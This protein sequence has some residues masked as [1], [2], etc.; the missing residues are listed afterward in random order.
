MAKKIKI[1]DSLRADLN[2]AARGAVAG[3]SEDL[4]NGIVVAAHDGKIGF[5]LGVHRRGHELRLDVQHALD[6]WKTVA[7]R[8]GQ[9]LE[10][11]CA[12]YGYKTANSKL[13]LELDGRARYVGQC[14]LAV[15]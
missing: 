8:T 9:A 10:N 2:A 3:V 12:A 13:F 5:V 7:E 14:K 11:V 4:V 15:A 6:V 1:N